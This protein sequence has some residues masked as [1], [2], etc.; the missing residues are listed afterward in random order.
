MAIVT[1]KLV[2]IEAL[3]AHSGYIVFMFR[4]AYYI[5]SSTTKVEHLIGFSPDCSR[6]RSCALIKERCLT[7][8]HLTWN[9]ADC[10]C[11]TITGLYSFSPAMLVLFSHLAMQYC[12]QTLRDTIRPV[13]LALSFSNSCCYSLPRHVC[14]IRQFCQ[15]W[16]CSVSSSTAVRTECIHLQACAPLLSYQLVATS[17]ASA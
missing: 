3:R 5:H 10:T 15:I 14:E 2:H 16:S 8:R 13:M 7:L 9:P 4:K 6:P 11:T 12:S 17:R 1:T